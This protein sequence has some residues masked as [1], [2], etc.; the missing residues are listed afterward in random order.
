RRASASAQ[1]IGSELHVTRVLSGS[2][3]KDSHKVR[4]AARLIDA[5]NGATIWSQMLDRDLRDATVLQEG[6]PSATAPALQ[7]R[8]G[9]MDSMSARQRYTSNAQAYDLYLRGRHFVTQRDPSGIHRA[10]QYFDSALALDSAYALAWSGLSDAYL[11]SGFDGV[12]PR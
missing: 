3:R 11:V 5:A 2:V 8:F 7:L 1:E 6:L 4:I 12:Q 10:V 9:T